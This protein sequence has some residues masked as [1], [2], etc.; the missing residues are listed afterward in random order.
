MIDSLFALKGLCLAHLLLCVCGVV[1][2]CLIVLCTLI[3]C[4]DNTFLYNFQ[5]ERHKNDEA[6]GKTT[7]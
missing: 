4:K 6:L 3:C 7:R 2:G 5:A 1:V